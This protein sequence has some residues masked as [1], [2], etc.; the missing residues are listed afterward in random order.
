MSPQ[1]Y[2]E[3]VRLSLCHVS[4]Q[5]ADAGG[6]IVTVER[7]CEWSLK[8]PQLIKQREEMN[9]DKRFVGNREQN[10]MVQF[11]SAEEEQEV[12]FLVY[13]NKYCYFVSI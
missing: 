6:L 7:V 2:R 9:F 11:A 4:F 1:L 13:S 12:L 8:G 10:G 3:L 5:I